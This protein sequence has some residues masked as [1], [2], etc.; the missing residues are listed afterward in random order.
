MVGVDST[1]GVVMSDPYADLL[2]ARR[3][4]AEA[5]DRR[6]SFAND[7]QAWWAW[8]KTVNAWRKR[9]HELEKGIIR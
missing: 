7:S 1:E 9:V 6:D 3:R 5:Q 4:Y 2:E 8:N